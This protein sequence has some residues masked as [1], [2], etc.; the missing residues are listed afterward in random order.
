MAALLAGGLAG[1]NGSGSAQ[2]TTQREH[3]TTIGRMIAPL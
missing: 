3:P 1:I 2:T